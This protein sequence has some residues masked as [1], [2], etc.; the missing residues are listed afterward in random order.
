VSKQLHLLFNLGLYPHL[1][2]RFSPLLGPTISVVAF[3][4]FDIWSYLFGPKKQKRSEKKKER[5][6]REKANLSLQ[7]QQRERKKKKES[8]FVFANLQP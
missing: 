4:K 5:E 8:K 7:I 3:P 6:E 2:T 1:K